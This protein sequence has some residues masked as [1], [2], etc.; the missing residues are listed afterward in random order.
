MKPFE[1]IDCKSAKLDSYLSDDLAGV[2]ESEV[3]AHLEFCQACRQRLANLAGGD[4]WLKAAEEMLADYSI[5]PPKLSRSQRDQ[6][7]VDG[8]FGNIINYLRQWMG[9]TDDPTK[10]GRVGHFEV[11]GIVGYGGAGAVLKAND[12]RLNR[13]VALKVLLPSL[14]YNGSAR[15]RFEQESRSAAAIL[16]PN[17]VP[18]FAVDSF[19]GHPYIAM[20][21]VDGGSLQQRIDRDGPLEPLEVVRIAS[22]IAQA[23]TAAHAQGVVHR[24]IKPAN[25]LLETAVERVFVT[26]FGLARMVDDAATHSMIIA[27]TP[28]FMAP[29]QCSGE[30]PNY[31]SD[32]FSLGS[33]MYAMCTGHPP[34]GSHTLMG[35]LRQVSE[36]TPKRVR[37]INAAMPQWLE[38][39]IERLMMKQPGKRFSSAFRVAELLE[40]ELAHMQ[41]PLETSVPDRISYDRQKPV[42]VKS[43]FLE[44]S[45]RWMWLR[46]AVTG[47]M[48]ILAVF[49][50]ASGVRLLQETPEGA[51]N[52]NGFPTQVEQQPFAISV[53]QDAK[54]G[55]TFE[56]IKQHSF[57]IKPGQLLD[58]RERDANVSVIASDI[59]QVQV[60]VIRRV[61]NL[62][63]E[64]DARH[65]LSLHNP[66]FEQGTDGLVI[67]A[68]KVD[69]DRLRV[70]ER[71]IL[72][73]H[74]EIEVPQNFDT[75]IQVVD[76]AISVL[77]VSGNS[78]VT[79]E[80]GNIELSSVHGTVSAHTNDGDIRLDQ[81]EGTLNAETTDGTLSF[82]HCRGS[83]KA[84]SLDGT[85]SFKNCD[86]ELEVKTRSGRVKSEKNTSEIETQR[87]SRISKKSDC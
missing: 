72:R 14:A 34:F 33:V 86:G 25:I 2:E 51:T 17:V 20:P 42:S 16:H 13:I 57:D 6:S 24:D 38:A 32:L 15:Q 83:A 31:M 18:I 73:V 11:I 61:V 79:A 8:C 12:S 67:S 35:L 77:G 44:S 70:S 3:R 47:L 65:V 4:V 41:N 68:S 40:R 80:D 26:D 22:Q 76:G 52:A 36:G 29:E 53:V 74:Y 50:V 59:N 71:S 39:F 28:Q 19:N 58:V 75:K 5:E 85:I 48:I 30:S 64:A 49:G 37:A 56:S 62:D 84:K 10:I 82:T 66:T 43:P 27:G 45:I 63:D 55:R 21:Y 9:P 87:Y 7:D 78:I 54:F 69:F 81:C 23:L 1:K 60:K 46:R